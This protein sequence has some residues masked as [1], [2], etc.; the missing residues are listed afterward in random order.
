MAKRVS[1]AQFGGFIAQ[2]IERIQA[3]RQELEELQ[4]GFNGKYVE[5]KAQHD[6][7]LTS[8]VNQI[9]DD[10]EIA[11]PELGRMIAD[12]IGGE[13]ETLEAR[14]RE[15]KE[16]VPKAQKEADD[17]LASAQSEVERYRQVN[18]QFDQS[19]EEV[20][21]RRAE[22]Q[23]QLEELNAQVQKHGK[24]LGFLTNFGKI[25]KLDR[26]RQ[27]IIGQL[28]YAERELK[29]VRDKW[30]AKRTE[31]TS[32][33]EKA[34]A[35]WQEASIELA[36]LQ[37][38]AELLDDDV[39]RER[40][41]LL[42]AARQVVDDLKEHVACPNA[43]FQSELD[44]MVE[45][46]VTTDNYHD[47]LGKAAGLIALLDGLVEGLTSMQNSVGALVREQRM[48]SAHLPKLKVEIPR[49]AA[50]FHKQWDG[51]RAM[52]LDEKSIC[53]H[54]MDFVKNMEPIMETQLGNPAINQMFNS[55][56]E[57]LTRAAKSQWE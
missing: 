51:L 34:K 11:G 35:R 29:E 36:K 46:N 12:L 3:I 50:T 5:F 39:A 18:P 15:L 10:P 52:V 57:A 8:L 55:L 4:V 56:G 45:L 7:T 43:D 21:G 32:R 40:L 48:H 31:F 54:P 42:R 24:G 9:T 16:L 6:A 33:Q 2:N 49:P 37:G 47:G 20:K 28:Q 17:L 53:E 19:E 27:R 1:L 13:R 14:R 23:Q 30:E 41:A 38:E 25:S 26:Q 44:K 22:L